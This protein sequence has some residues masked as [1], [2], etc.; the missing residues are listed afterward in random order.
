MV[1]DDEYFPKQM[2]YE[3]ERYMHKTNVNSGGGGG[4]GSCLS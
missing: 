4:G 2:I 1:Y 3:D